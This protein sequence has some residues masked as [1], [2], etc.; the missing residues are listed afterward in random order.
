M[1]FQLQSFPRH[2]TVV[3]VEAGLVTVRGNEDD[4]DIVVRCELFVPL[5]EDRSKSTA[6]RAPMRRKIEENAL[7]FQRGGVEF[8]TASGLQLT[9]KSFDEAHFEEFVRLR[10]YF[11]LICL[12]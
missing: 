4:F 3:A 12:S 1:F 11:K 10:T 2:L 7:A 9:G 5:G 8:G 6:G